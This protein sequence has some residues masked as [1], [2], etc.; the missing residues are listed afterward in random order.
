MFVADEIQTGFARTG[1]Y[2]AMEH[3]E[4]IPDLITVSKSLGAGVPISGVIGRKE[5]MDKSD[6]GELGGT[7]SGSPLGCKAALAVLDIIEEENLN[8]RAEAI[9]KTVMDHFSQLAEQFDCIGDIRGLGAM[10]AMEIVEDKQTKEPSKKLTTKIIK[11][12]NERG[13]L[14]LSAGVYGN[15]IRLL[16]PLVITDELLEEGL[17]IL[18]HSIDAVYESSKVSLI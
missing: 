2:F 14:L 18:K 10:C 13:L 11:E 3:F 1:R 6:S 9:G 5:V 17:S 4:I 15:V 16:M 12:A 7:Y 8:E